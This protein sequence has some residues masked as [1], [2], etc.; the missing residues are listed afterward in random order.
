M[1]YPTQWPQ[2]FT[3]TIYDWK[4]VL[5]DDA[6]KNII[7]NCLHT[8]VRKE[9]IQLN[10]FV[11]M[12][13]HVHFIWQPLQHYS[14]SQIQTS[15][16]TFTSKEIKKQLSID[17]LQLLETM[18]VNKYDRAYQIWKRRPL[19]IE[20]FTQ[21]VFMQKLEYIHENPVRAGLVRYAEEYH[22]S[23]AKYYSTGVDDFNMLT[24][25]KGG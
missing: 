3:A 16:T 8:M 7:S 10:A 13:N 12:V 25:Y 22:Y 20:L 2:F 9:Q 1:R 19:N 15:F 17:D 24:H 6:Y 23:S 18:K 11:I 14:V 4:H 5:K 21:N